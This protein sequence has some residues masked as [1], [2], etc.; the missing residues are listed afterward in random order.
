MSIDPKELATI[1][2]RL[3]KPAGQ[4]LL[5]DFQQLRLGSADH[6]QRRLALVRCPRNGRRADPHQPAQQALV[7]DDL[8]VL[9]DH[10]PARQA[11]SQGRQVGH[12]AHRLHFLVAGQFIGQRHNIDRPL[13]VHQL[14]HAQE[15]A[16]VR[17][18]RKIVRVDLLG[19]FRVRRIVQQNGAENG[20]LGVDIGGQS[21]VEARQVGNGGHRKS[22]RK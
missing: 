15:D 5:A 8:D 1:W 16:P 7:L 10:R 13:R 3:W 19:G 14:G 20:L 2:S 18:E 21:G 22:R 12:P 9:F 6:L 17:V 11:L 4:A